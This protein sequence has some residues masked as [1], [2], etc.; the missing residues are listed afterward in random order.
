MYSIVNASF[1]QLI[2][3]EGFGEIIARSVKDFFAQ[4]QINYILERLKK[5]GVNMKSKSTNNLIENRFMGA[6]FVLTGTLPSMTRDEAS[7][8]ILKYG[9]RVTDSVSKK[10]TYLLA[11]RDAGSKLTKAQDLGINVINEGQFMNMIK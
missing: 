7:N 11:G 8:L 6:A 4:P 3:L 1:E 5:A 9:G 2:D 10:T